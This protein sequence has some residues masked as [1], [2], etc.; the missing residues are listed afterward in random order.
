MY[1]GITANWAQQTLTVSVTSDNQ[2]PLPYAYVYVNGRATTITDTLGI[3][4]IPIGGLV[5]GDTISSE[6]VGTAPDCKIY[7]ETMQKEGSCRLILDEVYSTLK[8]EEV[9]VKPDIRKMFYKHL[10]KTPPAPAHSGLEAPFSWERTD[11]A[12]TRQVKGQILATAFAYSERDSSDTWLYYPRIRLQTP[13][14]T[15]ALNDFILHTIHK[16]L[17]H[18]C[19]MNNSINSGRLVRRYQGQ[20]TQ[21]GYLG[22]KD[23]CRLFRLTFRTNESPYLIIQTLVWLAEDSGII[24]KFEAAYQYQGSPVKGRALAFC[25][26]EKQRGWKPRITYRQLEFEIR[27]GTERIQ[28]ISTDP[29]LSFEK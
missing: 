1:L 20:T 22:K 12:G 28:W 7:T 8:A 13:D 10:R 23:G 5:V 18:F 9:V 3:A 6:Y 4:H 24:R 26:L 27:N 17:D 14:D 15:T 19:R 21:Y 25:R 16:G 29:R 2:L 11:S